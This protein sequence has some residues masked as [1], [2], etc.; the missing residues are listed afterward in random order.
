MMSRGISF[1][2]VI[3]FKKSFGQLAIDVCKYKI[4]CAEVTGN[5]LHNITRVF[6]GHDTHVFMGDDTRVFLG[7]FKCLLCSHLLEEQGDG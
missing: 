1:S 7:H 2:D 6:F 4:G 3:F 5:I